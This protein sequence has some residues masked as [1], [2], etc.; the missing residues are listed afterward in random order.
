L[1]DSKNI[2]FEQFQEVFLNIN[3]YANIDQNV[4][5]SMKKMFSFLDNIAKYIEQSKI[6]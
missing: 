1:L 5:N 2:K 3:T 4:I 6:D